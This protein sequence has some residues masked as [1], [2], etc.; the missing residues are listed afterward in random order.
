MKLVTL[1]KSWLCST[2]IFV[3]SSAPLPD[4]LLV[5]SYFGNRKQ[6]VDPFDEQTLI[7]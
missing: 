4:E 7:D 1:F 2:P 3:I 6:V 5:C